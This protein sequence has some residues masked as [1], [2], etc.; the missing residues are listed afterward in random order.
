MT[1]I[2]KDKQVIPV[3]LI[4]AGPC[5]IT[6]IKKKKQKDGYN[7]IQIGF[8]EKK[9]KKI[10]KTEREN[11]YYHLRECRVS[12]SELEGLKK[13]EKINLSIFKEG[14]KIKIS[15]LSKG[16][17]FQG[18]VKRW[19]FSGRNATHGVKHEHRS[20]GSVGASGVERVFK[21]KKMPGRCGNTRITI[22]NLEVVKIDS[23]N[24][25]LAVKGA[26]PGRKGTLIELRSN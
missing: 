13:G 11:P 9:F 18:G 3:T 19:G 16:K 15:A 12:E 25:L 17:G 5:I 22:K 4:K 8:K 2:F 14:D 24:N 7:A 26:I 23:L 21:G 10:K 1:Q 6:Q 20:L